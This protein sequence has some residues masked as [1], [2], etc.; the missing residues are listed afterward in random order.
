M[1]H[2][3]CDVAGSGRRGVLLAAIDFDDSGIAEVVM[4]GKRFLAAMR[5]P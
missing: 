4:R 5:Y 2:Y 3:C 1:S